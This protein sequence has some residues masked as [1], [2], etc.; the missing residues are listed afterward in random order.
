MSC[1]K[2]DKA[3]TTYFLNFFLKENKNNVY[4]T[5]IVM[6]I[7]SKYGVSRQ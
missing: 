7:L 3:N 6:N 2:F 5:L 4:R 1:P